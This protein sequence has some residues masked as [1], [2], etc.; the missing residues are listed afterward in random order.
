MSPTG[1]R[2]MLTTGR[3]EAM[4]ASA[5]VAKV[6]MEAKERIFKKNV[7]GVSERRWGG[8]WDKKAGKLSLGRK[9]RNVPTLYI[10]P[11]MHQIIGL[12]IFPKNSNFQTNEEVEEGSPW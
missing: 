5:N 10:P 12:S 3:A 11:R 6:T 1:V 2:A 9:K 8:G 7:G 4:D